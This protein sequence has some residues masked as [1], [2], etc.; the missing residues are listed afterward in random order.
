M[1]VNVIVPV[2][3]LPRAANRFVNRTVTVH[4]EPGVSGTPV[5]PSVPATMLKMYC[6]GFGFVIAMLVTLTCEP[7]VAA[8]LLKVTKPVPLS[9]P[10]GSVIVGAKMDTGARLA[11]LVP[12]KVTEL[13][14]I[15]APV[16]ETVSV[17][18]MTPTV[19]GAANWTLTV[20]ELATAN[21]VPQFGAPF[22]NVPVV[23]RLKGCGVPPPKVK[24]NPARPELPVLVMVTFNAALVVPV[25]QLPKSSVAGVTVA[26]KVAA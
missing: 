6:N 24:A 9:T 16:A 8:V 17:L 26:L 5:H 23:T 15:V 18:L 13:G 14:V 4:D 2:R 3:L 22:G 20:H 12:T 11:T 25:A 19:E 10:V 7:P 1:S 21:V